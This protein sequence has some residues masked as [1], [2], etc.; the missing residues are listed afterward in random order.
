VSF[1]EAVLVMGLMTNQVDP[2]VELEGLEQDEEL[3]LLESAI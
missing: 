1:E 2:E 3:A